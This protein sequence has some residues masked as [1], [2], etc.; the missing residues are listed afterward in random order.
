M[1]LD[2]AFEHAVGIV[3]IGSAETDVRHPLGNIFHHQFAVLPL[4]VEG[5]VRV[6]LSLIHI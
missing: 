4:D 1:V 3:C 6:L 5:D 2:E